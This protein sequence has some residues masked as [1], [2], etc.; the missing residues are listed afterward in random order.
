MNKRP[1]NTWLLIIIIL[2]F[3][4]YQ[5][6]RFGSAIHFWDFL[7]YHGARGGPLYIL[8]SG[9]LWSAAGLILLWGILFRHAWV[10]W[11]I[12]CMTIL[13]AAWYWLDRTF[14][15]YPHA[16]WPL[17]LV[18][19]FVFIVFIFSTLLSTTTQDYFRTQEKQRSTR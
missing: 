15:Q 18:M 2:G 1:F 6:F 5:G 16:N 13:Y 11:V 19:T 4:L 3:T 10:R 12:P 8:L 7:E 17:S 14:L 9:T